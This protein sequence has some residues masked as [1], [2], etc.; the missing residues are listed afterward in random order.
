[1]A[2]V[3]GFEPPHDGVKV[4]CLSAWLYPNIEG[5]LGYDEQNGY[6]YEFHIFVFYYHHKTLTLGT[7]QGVCYL[8]LIYL[9]FAVSVLLQLLL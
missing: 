8:K 1:M 7:L 2:G 4:R 6:G 3:G 9:T 5:S